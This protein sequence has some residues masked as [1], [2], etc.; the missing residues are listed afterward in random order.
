MPFK[1]NVNSRHN[2]PLADAVNQ[3]FAHCDNQN[4]RVRA[5]ITMSKEKQVLVILPK[6]QVRSTLMKIDII[7]AAGPDRESGLT[8]RSHAD[9]LS[10]P[11]P[12]TSLY[13]RL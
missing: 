11:A 4:S 6:N 2:V 9:Q 12:L 3:T 5:H 13:N 7:K 10:A 1:L 8:L